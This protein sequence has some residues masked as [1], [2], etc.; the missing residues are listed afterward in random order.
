MLPTS[1]QATLRSLVL[2]LRLPHFSVNIVMHDQRTFVFHG[3]G[4]LFG[5]GVAVAA[6]VFSVAT[7]RLQHPYFK[8][9]QG[10]HS[11]S[12]FIVPVGADYK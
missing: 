10:H 4:T 3:R 6:V 11:D 8:T 5:A 2:R 1:S 12:D 7:D 9:M